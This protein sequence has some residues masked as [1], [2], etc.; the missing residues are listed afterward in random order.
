MHGQST[1]G[2]T[3][4]E[5]YAWAYDRIFT[6]GWQRL[7]HGRPIGRYGA[8]LERTQW[9]DPES[10]E[11]FQVQ[12]LRELLR[13]AGDRVPYYR[14]VFARTGF[15]PR[16]VRSR[17]D[18]EALPMLTREIVRDRAADLVDPARGRT[19]TKDTS[20]TTGHPV[21]FES[22]YD[23]E[24]WRTAMRLRAYGWAGYRQGMPA[25][26]YWGGV[27]AEVLHGLHGA[28]VRLDR[29]LRREWYV[30]AGQRGDDAMERTA[31]RIEQDRPHVVIGY[32]Q[33]LALFARWVNETGRRRWRDIPVLCGAEALLADDRVAIERAFGRYVYE[34]YGSR[35]VMLMSSDCGARQGMHLAEENVLL[36]VVRDGRGVAPGVSGE[37]L[38]TDLHN[39]AMPLIRYRNGDM[40][41][42][43]APGRCSCGRSLRRLEKVDG[44][45]L[46]T[47]RD[48]QGRAIPGTVFV[49][50][51]V[52]QEGVVRQYQLV[53]RRTGEATLK[54]VPGPQWSKERFAPTAARFASRLAGLPFEVVTV[55][56]IAPGQSGKLR[57]VVVEPSSPAQGAD[58]QIDTPAPTMMAP[59]SGTTAGGGPP[60][61]GS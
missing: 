18:L 12:A 53:Q 2:E 44:R 46:D 51:M 5:L 21:R 48:G 7:A 23:S 17:A 43:A 11:R 27:Q 25:L 54:V 35:E 13:H 20:G 55:R 16:D 45:I 24:S 22:C 34:T 32:T 3:G 30:D 31:R 14:E 42:L 1:A 19:C 15:D 4:R 8:L 33:A 36:E 6:G 39:R 40:A 50:M 28:K 26:F 10:L 59:A 29:A 61:L 41:T 60:S 38:V 49:W 57:P 37:V 56:E 52:G 47:L 9:L 58:A